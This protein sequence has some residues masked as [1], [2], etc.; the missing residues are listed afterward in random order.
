[1]WGG[2]GDDPSEW[3]AAFGDDDLFA[4]SCDFVEH[5]DAMCFEF[6]NQQSFHGK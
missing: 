3:F 6:R 5:A 4:E 1:M 2:D